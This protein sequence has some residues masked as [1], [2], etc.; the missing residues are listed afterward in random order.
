LKGRGKS[1]FSNQTF[2]KGENRPGWGL[3]KDLIRKNFPVHEGAWNG[4]KDVSAKKALQISPY[5]DAGK[6]LL[7]LKGKIYG[8]NL[9][10]KTK[11]EREPAKEK[12]T[13]R[14]KN[15]ERIMEKSLP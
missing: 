14:R 13:R 4:G 15:V 11:G 10:R 6:A 5:K 12:C 9:K 8:K 3:E 7:R 1:T 2:S